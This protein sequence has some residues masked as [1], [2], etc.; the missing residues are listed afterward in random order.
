MTDVMVNA[1]VSVLW[2]HR[3][4]TGGYGGLAGLAV[5]SLADLEQGFGSALA[6]LKTY[7]VVAHPT[8]VGTNLIHTIMP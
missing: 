5:D 8:R 4:G 1:V 6:A 3:T 7:S 2:F